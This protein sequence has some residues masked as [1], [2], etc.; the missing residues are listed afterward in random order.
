MF[1]SFQF[2]KYKVMRRLASSAL[3]EVFLAF[4]ETN[5]EPGRLVALKR[6]LPD[7][8]R[9]ETFSDLFRNEAKLG[10]IMN[11]P[12]VVK[13]IEHG[14]INNELYLAMEYIDGLDLWRL[15][16]KTSKTEKKISEIESLYIVCEVLKA[17]SYIHNL[18][19]SMGNKLGIVHHDVSP[20]NILISRIG[21]VKLGD[22]GISFAQQKNLSAGERKMVLRGKVHYVSP[23]QIKGYEPD[24]RSDIFSLGVVLFELLF[25]KKPFEGPTDLSIMINIKDGRYRIEPAAKE[26]L[27]PRLLKILTKALANDPEERYQ[28][29]DS[30]ISD[31][32]EF[33]GSGKLFDAG[34]ELASLISSILSEGIKTPMPIPSPLHFEKKPQ[35][36]SPDTNF[37]QGLVE[38]TEKTP[39][40]Q[41]EEHIVKKSSGEIMGVMPLSMLIE[42]I[43]ADKITEEDFVSIGG[44]P[45]ERIGSIPHLSKYLPSVTPTLKIS[46][47]GAPDI[48]GIIF[49]DETVSKIFYL[50]YLKKETG[51]LI[52]ENA[53]VRKEI[54]IEDGCPSYASSNLASELLGEF[55][56]R[57]GIITRI[58]LELALAMMDK[59]GGHLGETL[60]GLEILDS[61]TLLSAIN[62][63]IKFRI[64]DIFTWESGSYSFFRNAKYMKEG[65][66]L[67]AD[68]LELIRDGFLFAQSEENIKNWI[69]IHKNNI[70]RLSTDSNVIDDWKIEVPI[71]DILLKLEK[72]LA[73]FKIIEESSASGE[74]VLNKTMKLIRLGCEI[75][76]IE[77][78]R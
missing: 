5:E 66:K 27:S 22:F 78:I 4:M 54:F 62:D 16:R 14:N 18:T 41:M 36:K 26:R 76:F 33:A 59:F 15:M 1:E 12:N 77:E 44:K 17:L 39:L 56:V 50:F 13:I 11:H 28:D 70:F 30:M 61:I 72:P 21:E 2:G 3:S 43:I 10:E 69:E 75:G 29:A 19:D 23:E 71:R 49:Q 45:F 32:E 63:Q 64:F 7:I 68:P 42:Q 60:L 48:K 40:H 6:L 74:N 58:E 52:F 8:A 25:G 38:E 9:T 46:E 20:S 67:V 31:I 57:K 34:M 24:C 65:F 73:L 47:L 53:S 37:L 51:L 35:E 55:L